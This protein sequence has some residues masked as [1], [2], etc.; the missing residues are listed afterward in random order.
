MPY[1]L[2]SLSEKGYW[3]KIQPAIVSVHCSSWLP[4]R[5]CVSSRRNGYR[6]YLRTKR[7]KYKRPQITSWTARCNSEEMSL[8]KIKFTDEV[9]YHKLRSATRQWAHMLSSSPRWVMW[10]QPK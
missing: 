2:Y 1:I 3:K 4:Q 7:S 5:N 10:H 8:L 6:R 9:E